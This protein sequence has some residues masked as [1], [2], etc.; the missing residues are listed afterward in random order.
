M[1]EF[2]GVNYEGVGGVNYEG[3][4]ESLKKYCD[5]CRTSMPNNSSASCKRAPTCAMSVA[6]VTTSIESKLRGS[7]RRKL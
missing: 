1:R 4:G 3:V 5:R 2:G 6:R 7:W